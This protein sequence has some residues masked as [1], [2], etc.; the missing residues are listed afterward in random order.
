VNGGGDSRDGRGAGGAVFTVGGGLFI[1]SSTFSG[2]EA[3]TVTGGGG[4]AIV[5]YEPEW[6]TNTRLRIRNSI[7]AN[8]GASECYTRGGVSTTGS[9]NNVITDSTLNNLDNPACPG[10]LSSDD[11]GLQPLLKY[12]PGRTPTM[13]IPFDS[14]AV[15][16]ADPAFSPLDDQRG[17]ARPQGLAP[18][19]G[20]YEAAPSGPSTQIDLVPSL[21]DGDN[22]WYVSAVG[23]AIGAVDPDGT[24]AETRCALDPASVPASFADLPAGQCAI[25]GAGT[26]GTHAFYAASIDN[27]G[28]AEAS[29][30]GVAFKIDRTA[31]TLDPFLNVSQIVAGQTGVVA[32]PNGTDAT[33]GL[34]SQS[35]DPVNTTVPGLVT[36]ECTATDNA[37]N[38]G[39]GSVSFVVQYRVLGF[40]SPVP[41]SKWRAGQTVPVKVALGGPSARVSDDVGRALARDCRVTFVVTGAQVK[42]PQC[43]KYDAATDQFIFNW[44]LAKQ[45]LGTATIKVIVSYPG[46]AVTTTISEAIEIIR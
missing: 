34:A 24:V 33:S 14:V 12:A 23:F 4:G 11:P 20:A 41:G 45:P 18:D 3:V 22:G 35:C 19:I 43:L 30:A 2:N 39:T 28:N 8:N 26:D 7:V 5:A 9:T 36:V 31:P 15:D 44:K 27:E 10:V 13:A 16:N 21:P 25:V 42:A 40:F 6:D 1:D 37:G 29:V 46:S 17:I 38:I 32:D